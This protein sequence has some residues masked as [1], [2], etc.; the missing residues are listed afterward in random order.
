MSSEPR[1]STES[2]E[3]DVIIIG[4]GVAGLSAAIELTKLGRSYTVVEGSH[5]IGGRAYSEE[6]SPGVWFD[7]GCSYLHQGDTN[8]F[9]PIADDL[10]VILGKHKKHMFQPDRVR[11]YFNGALLTQAEQEAY[12]QYMQE[13]ED[14]IF[15]SAEARNDVAISDLIDLDNPYAIPFMISMADL[16]AQD[17]DLTSAADFASFGHGTD[18]PVLNGYGNLVAKWG[19][20]IPVSLNTKV[21]SIDWS[22]VG[23]RV[24]TN[25]GTLTGRSVLSTVS[26]GVLGANHI[27]FKPG[28]P[29]WKWDAINNLPTGTMNKICV[30]F[31][32]DVFSAHGQGFHQ[33]WR[34]DS[35][36]NDAST[37]TSANTESGCGIEASIMGLNTAVVFVGGRHAQWLEKQGQQAGL[38]F[39]VSQ[40]AD[41][42]GNDIRKSVGNSIVTAWASEPWTLGSY[43]C[44]QPGQ[45]HQRAELARSID[46]QLFFAGEATIIGAQAT[47]HGALQSGIRAAHEIAGALK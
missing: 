8:P 47:A 3:T 10:G 11:Q 19:A 41:V 40:I 14:Q 22:K 21:E 32:K 44:A 1:K 27:D 28:L 24:E 4:A 5:R 39:A 45:A 26:T 46:E 37:D 2:T 31:T 43:S 23:V 29:D 15:D 12:Y 35:S 7:L 42:F 20:D 13:C 36:G 6:V 38:D 17:I 9:V 30:H 34:D 16:N 25:K 18:I 33:T